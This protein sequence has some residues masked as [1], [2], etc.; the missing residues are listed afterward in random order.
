MAPS[1]AS[2]RSASGII[3]R[4]ATLKDV[5]ELVH[6]RRAMWEDL[7]VKGKAEHDRADRI[8][9]RWVRSRMTNHRLVG[10]IAR[11]R[12]GTIAGGGCVWLQ[13]VQPR[14]HRKGTLQPYLLSMYTEPAFRGYGVATKIV[15]AAID[16]T[17]KQGYE[18][19]QLH[20][21]EMGRG[22]YKRL[23]FKRTWE[24]RYNIEQPK[25]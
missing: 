16:W 21:S 10:W 11:K 24:M 23:G 15:Q 8:Y 7:G 2:H 22:V 1:R 18:R 9:G 12:D 14:P 3:V 19:L 6:Q 17:T 13:E 25:K 4:R 5:P 20:A